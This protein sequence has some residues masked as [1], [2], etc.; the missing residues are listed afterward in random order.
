MGI[1]ERAEK[2][3]EH[4]GGLWN[5]NY[6]GGREI[7]LPPAIAAKSALYGIGTNDVYSVRNF[8]LFVDQSRDP[9]FAVGSKGRYYFP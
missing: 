4:N 3:F 6:K 5:R 2:F 1:A 9:I 7:V 8:Q